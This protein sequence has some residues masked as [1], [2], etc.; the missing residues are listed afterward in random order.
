MKIMI[1]QIWTPPNQLR[2]NF[3][4]AESGKF[5]NLLLCSRYGWK[6]GRNRKN[7]T[8]CLVLWWHIIFFQLP[9]LRFASDA[10]KQITRNIDYSFSIF[11]N[12]FLL[13]LFYKV[14]ITFFQYQW[15][16]RKKIQVL[17]KCRLG[18]PPPHTHRYSHSYCKNF[19]QTLE[20]NEDGNE[21][22]KELKLIL[23]SAINALLKTEKRKRLSF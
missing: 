20:S 5:T 19:K 2:V 15:K 6:I 10:E 13:E 23:I 1:F 4:K 22:K 18:A 11:R 12:W 17:F 16:L 14:E 21:T 3:E 9:L 8:L 7:P